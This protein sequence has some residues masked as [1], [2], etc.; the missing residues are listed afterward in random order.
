M[1]GIYAIKNIENGKMYIGQSTN[2]SH[3]KSQHLCAL[4][5]GK[6]HSRSLQSE[7]NENPQA[8]KF[9]ILCKCGES[10]LDDL[11]K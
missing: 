2:L 5:A 9:E 11:E 7:Y 6:H 1:I 3:R 8:F 4:K 10:D